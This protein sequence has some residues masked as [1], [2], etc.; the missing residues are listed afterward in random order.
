MVTALIC[1]SQDRTKALNLLRFISR[2]WAKRPVRQFHFDSQK[3]RFDSC[4]NLFQT[5][6]LLLANIQF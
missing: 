4:F 2:R 3:P 1:W 5:A 6:I